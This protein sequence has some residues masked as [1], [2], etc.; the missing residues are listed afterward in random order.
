MK[1]SEIR[2]FLKAAAVDTPF[3]SVLFHAG[4]DEPEVPGRIVMLTPS[5]G[6]GL[7]TEWLTDSRGLDV[8]TIGEQN[9]YDGAEDLAFW[10]DRTIL[11]AGGSR[12]MGNEWVI[13]VQRFG[14]APYNTEHD[15]ADR[16]HFTASYLYE[17]QSN[18]ALN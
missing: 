13:D 15:N 17:V 14:S 12:L 5:T 3:E 18:L 11:G 1:V 10:V 2:D 4:V 9:D 7:S 6:A 16:Y 8:I